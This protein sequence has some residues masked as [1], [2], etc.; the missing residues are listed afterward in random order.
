L[1]QATQEVPV[2]PALRGKKSP[3]KYLLV[4][5]RLTD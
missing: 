5:Y 4:Q 3:L 2:P 1:R